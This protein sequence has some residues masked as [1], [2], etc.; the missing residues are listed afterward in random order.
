MQC[1]QPGFITLNEGVARQ[2]PPNCSDAIPRKLTRC[3]AKLYRFDRKGLW[4][5]DR[6]SFGGGF[7]WILLRKT[8]GGLFCPC[9]VHLCCVAAM[10]GLELPESRRHRHRRY[11]Y[12]ACERQ[13]QICSLR[14]CAFGDPAMSEIARLDLPHSHSAGGLPRAPLAIRAIGF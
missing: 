5:S 14:I 9:G 7:Q 6:Q 3:R 10:S 12:A 13:S 4:R 11:A 2:L 8:S 1:T